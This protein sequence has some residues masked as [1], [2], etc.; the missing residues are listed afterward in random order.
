MLSAGITALGGQWRAGLTRDVTHLF[1]L[2]PGSNKYETAMH[3]QEYTKVKVILPHWFDD[4]VRLGMGTLPTA[5]YEWPDP[6]ILRALPEG[7]T[8]GEGE[9]PNGSAMK[10]KKLAAE[11]KAL[12]RT[13]LWTPGHEVPVGQVGQSKDIWQGRK[14]LLSPSLELTGGRREAVEAGIRRAKG[15]I[16][17][18]EAKGG[19]GDREEE[20]RRLDEADVLITRYR[21]GA[22]YAKVRTFGSK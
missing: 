4:A 2:S 11:K 16:V 13:T 8:I 12:Y 9:D 14:I 19:D 7:A 10:M 20:V 17:E 5:V 21:A 22:A 1:A 3:F 6:K 15:A 18:F